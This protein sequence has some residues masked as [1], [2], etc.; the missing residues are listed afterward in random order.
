M[1]VSWACHPA[2]H[3]CTVWI[4][5]SAANRYGRS[6]LGVGAIACPALIPAPGAWTGR[7]AAAAAGM[8][9]A[10]K[11]LSLG[12]EVAERSCFSQFSLARVVSPGGK[13][14]T[15][16]FIPF[17]KTQQLSGELAAALSHLYPICIGAA[18]CWAGV[19]FLLGLSAGCSPRMGRARRKMWWSLSHE[20]VGGEL[21]SRR[22]AGCSAV[23][24]SAHTPFYSCIS[25]NIPDSPCPSTHLPDTLL[26]AL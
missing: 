16:Q 13:A 26:G 9:E 7:T 2:F 21:C 25:S 12:A 5:P 11:C 8:F 6:R 22:P 3:D 14:A 18:V 17:P 23:T 10:M 20:D 19:A 15:S 4:V 1:R 24:L